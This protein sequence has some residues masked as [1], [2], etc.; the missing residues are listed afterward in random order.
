[1]LLLSYLSISKLCLQVA[2]EARCFLCTFSNVARTFLF[3]MI[4]MIHVLNISFNL[5]VFSCCPT[6]IWITAYVCR[7]I[8]PQLRACPT[9]RSNY[10][11]CGFC[12]IGTKYK[13][14]TQFPNAAQQKPSPSTNR[15][16]I[17]VKDMSW[18]GNPSPHLKL[19]GWNDGSDCERGWDACLLS[20]RT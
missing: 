4:T 10:C 9:F 5:C 20:A 15:D 1:M 16:V 8:F 12:F 14:K 17:N 7:N 11:K 18:H 13:N 2:Y 6:P 19:Q 3:I